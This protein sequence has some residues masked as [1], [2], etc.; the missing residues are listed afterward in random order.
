MWYQSVAGGKYD[1][2][3]MNEDTVSGGIATETYTGATPK[4][5]ALRVRKSDDLDDPR[6]LAFS[7]IVTIASGTGYTRTVQLKQNPTLN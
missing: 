6:Y 1:T 7:D 5:C 2:Q 3:V 4:E